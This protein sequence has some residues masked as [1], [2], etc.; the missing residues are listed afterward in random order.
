MDPSNDDLESYDAVCEKSVSNGYSAMI[1]LTWGGWEAMEDVASANGFP[2]LRIDSSNQQFIKVL[3][4][5]TNV[6]ELPKWSNNILKI[7][8]HTQSIFKKEQIYW[9]DKY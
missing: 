4:H 3:I 9:F 2:Y 8:E 5:S 1:D 6:L 7:E